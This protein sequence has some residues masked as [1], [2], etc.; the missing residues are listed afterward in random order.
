MLIPSGCSS[1]KQKC[2]LAIL[3][4]KFPILETALPHPLAAQSELYNF[5]I[6]WWF[7]LLT[8]AVPLT[9]LAVVHAWF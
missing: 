3:V 1:S 8:S 2:L 4:S 5:A 9:S 6:D 7:D